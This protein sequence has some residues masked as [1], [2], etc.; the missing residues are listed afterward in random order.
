MEEMDENQTINNTEEPEET[1]E[2]LREQLNAANQSVAEWKQKYEQY[3]A[4]DYN[5]KLDKFIQETGVRNSIYAEHLKR[6]II[7]QNLQFDDNGVLIGGDD[8]VKAMRNSYPDAFLLN[9]NGYGAAAPTSGRA[10]S[11]GYRDLFSD[12]F[13][14]ST[15]FP[16]EAEPS[17]NTSW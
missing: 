15:G 7:E 11:I 14:S 10:P 5:N 1:M 9:P 17:R 3:K 12:S 16:E 6:Q 13:M 4:A 8:V 2:S